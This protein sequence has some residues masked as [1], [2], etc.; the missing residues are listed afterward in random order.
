MMAF[1]LPQA[2]PLLKK[3][4][5]RRR[6]RIRLLKAIDPCCTLNSV[7]T[8]EPN[9]VND[10]LNSIINQGKLLSGTLP[11]LPENTILKSID[12]SKSSSQ[13]AGFTEFNLYLA[14][15]PFSG[16]RSSKDPM[17]VIPDS[18]ENDMFPMMPL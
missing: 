9:A 16:D 7:N 5:V 13:A 3:T 11:Q 1:L 15:E 12:A 6:S 8:P 14:N 10:H 4:Y 18:F 2:V 17:T